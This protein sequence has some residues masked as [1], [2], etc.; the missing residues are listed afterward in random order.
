MKIRRRVS[1]WFVNTF[2]SGTHFFSLKRGLL[3]FAGVQVG[4]NTK[5]VGPLYITGDLSIGEECWIG[6]ALTI[7]GNG[8]VRIGD[9][10]DVAPNVTFNTGTHEIGTAQ[11]RAGEGKSVTICV[12]NGVWI[13]EGAAFANELQVGDSSV[14]AC[15]ACVV[16]EVLPNTL[17]GG[18]P[19]KKIKDLT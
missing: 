7:N 8:A 13:G 19:A 17:V 14:I 18:V 1:L 16:K 3:R 4:K 2:F 15:R 5:V 6:K 10:C 9:R 11:R 12:G